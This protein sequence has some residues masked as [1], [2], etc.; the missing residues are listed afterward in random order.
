MSIVSKGAKKMTSRMKHAKKSLRSFGRIMHQSKDEA[1]HEYDLLK[2]PIFKHSKKL[3]S[4]EDRGLWK[5]EE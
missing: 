1:K 3:P 2:R 5:G 4:C